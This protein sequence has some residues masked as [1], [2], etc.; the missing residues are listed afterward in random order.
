MNNKT[1]DF[2]KS[3]LFLISLYTRKK[4]YSLGNADSG[5]M[6][7]NHFGKI[8]YHE[9]LAA[10]DLRPGVTLDQF[11][12]TPTAIHGI[13][14]TG[15]CPKIPDCEKPKSCIGSATQCEAVRP[16][17]IGT[18]STRLLD[19]IVDHFKAG[20][21]Y[22]IKMDKDAARGMES[23]WQG[24]FFGKAIRNERDLARSRDYVKKSGAEYDAVPD[25]SEADVHV[26][27]SCGQSVKA[28]G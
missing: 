4:E 16:G 17:K 24:G 1:Y 14:V 28:A 20:A 2:T 27:E 3:G 7:L 15:D 13:L 8:V 10:M 26:C 5:R 23:F 9:F 19:A 6:H 11:A 25:K 21:N 22:K 18:P 12:I